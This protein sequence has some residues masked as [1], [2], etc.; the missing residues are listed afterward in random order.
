MTAK[1][2]DKPRPPRSAVSRA[3]TPDT[4]RTDTPQAGRPA[5]AARRPTLYDSSYV[6]C[7]R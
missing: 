5:K 7:P 4:R 2:T 1:R 6:K 3:L